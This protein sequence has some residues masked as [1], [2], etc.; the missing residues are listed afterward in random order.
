MDL[1][2]E[3]NQVDERI[4]RPATDARDYIHPMKKVIKK[5]QDRKVCGSKF[6]EEKLH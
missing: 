6:L 3:V 4:I 5:R 2:E 1:L